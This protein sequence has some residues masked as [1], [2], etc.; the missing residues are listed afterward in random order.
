MLLIFNLFL[1]L[2]MIVGAIAAI[3]F[4]FMANWPLAAGSALTCLLSW[5]IFR[6][7]PMR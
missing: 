5:F 6:R 1:M 2:L 4:T 3:V 7:I